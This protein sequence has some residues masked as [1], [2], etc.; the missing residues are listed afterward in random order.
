MPEHAVHT[1]RLRTI[2]DF[3]LVLQVEG[4]G[5]IWSE[6]AG[7]SL[8]THPGDL[9]FFPPDHL[10]GW[11]YEA[12]THLAIHFD[13][14]ARPDLEAYHNLC[15]L[16]TIVSYQPAKMM[17]SF[18]LCVA[19]GA[20]PI[21]TLPLIITPRQ[22]GLWHERLEPLVHLWHR[23]SAHSFA[24]QLLVQETL[25]WAF[26]ELVKEGL[27]TRC[28]KRAGRS[29]VLLVWKGMK[30][31]ITSAGSSNASPVKLQQTIVSASRRLKREAKASSADPG[32]PSYS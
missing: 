8:D 31:P 7:G 16:E 25:S 19:G 6:R 18:S 2:A 12:G 5:W 28:W 1:A 29:V 9:I 26:Q 11:A 24:G 4:D 3:E 15:R 21:I 10:H 20:L 17:P 14:H 27:P 23:H 30:I 32:I 13:F 22:P